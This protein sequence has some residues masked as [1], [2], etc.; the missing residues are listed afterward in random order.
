MDAVRIYVLLFGEYVSLRIACGS[1]TGKA[2]RAFAGICPVL[3]FFQGAALMIW[4]IGTVRLIYPLLVHLPT[5]LLLTL[6]L[7]VKWGAALVSVAISHSLCQ[8]LRW[9][10]LVVYAWDAASVASVIV[11]LALGQM[12]L[13]LLDRYCLGAIHD[14]ITGSARLLRW[15]G[16]LP[17]V[18]YLYEYF[19]LYTQQSYAGILALH[20]LL[21]TRM[22]LFFVL[23]V[24]AY[25]HEAE[26]HEQA[27]WQADTLE[28]KLAHVEQEIGTL[29]AIQD[30]TAIYRHD[31]HHHLMM[32]DSLL[33]TDM[34]EQAARYISKTE[35]E[36][37]AISL[38]RYCENETANLLL[39]AFKDK[40]ERKG[41]SMSVKASL[42]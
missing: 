6:L 22:V 24:T 38:A 21:T 3:L 23:F 26:K 31:L 9:I 11:H 18:Y 12:L 1:M 17:A 35:D 30:Q 20:E 4:D 19:M 36:I 15:F 33:A 37:A 29:R 27:K 8:L 42:P 41:I 13:L 34:R 7:N 5:L 2:W 16:A 40:A 28:M 10:G 25:R 39:C 14:V 32:I